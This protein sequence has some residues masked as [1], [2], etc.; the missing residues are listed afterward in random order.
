MSPGHPLLILFSYPNLLF[1]LTSTSHFHFHPTVVHSVYF[2]QHSLLVDLIT[3]T[4]RYSV[5]F[6]T[7]SALALQG[8]V[9]QVSIHSGLMININHLVESNPLTSELIEQPCHSVSD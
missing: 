3:F 8:A 7:L 4:M 9:A 5:V 2:T 6:A 1:H